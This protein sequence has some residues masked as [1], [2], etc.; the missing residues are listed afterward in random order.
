METENNTC[1]WKT[2]EI[3]IKSEIE[4]QLRGFDMLTEFNADD[5]QC[6]AKTVLI[7]NHVDGKT[8]EMII[9][10]EWKTAFFC[11]W[12]SYWVNTVVMLYRVEW[13]Q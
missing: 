5:K 1:D 3:E 7:E 11:E 13:K 9:H 6:W 8:M 2:I 12:N 10:W 4:K